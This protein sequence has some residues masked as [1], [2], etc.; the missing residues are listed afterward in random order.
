MFLDLVKKRRS[1]RR[2]LP[3][4][5][6]GE[7]IELCLEAARRAPSA[8][9]AQPWRFIVVE[10]AGLRERLGRAAFSGI[11][12]TNAFAR[13]APVIVVAATV[14]TAALP[15]L[16]GRYQGKSYPL[17]DLG[18]AGEHLVLQATELGLGTCWIGW[19]NTKKVGRL[20]GLS[21]REKP[22]MLITL[23]YPAAGG[24]VSASPRKKR[25]ET[26]RYNPDR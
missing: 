13:R 23:G 2:Y 10:E 24:G 3:R 12:A 16:A 22:V 7:K 17:I 4:P 5:V 18:I 6:E 11:Y 14:P 15:R 20:L 19:F 1:V 9:N 8:C 21:R 25:G 26:I